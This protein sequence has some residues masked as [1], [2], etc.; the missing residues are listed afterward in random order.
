M[1]RRLNAAVVQALRQP[2][3]AQRLTELGFEIIG[4]T[5]EE[6]AAWTAAQLPKWDALVR[7][8]AIRPE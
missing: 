7:T 6:F 1:I 2:D 4:G 5:P 8:A 3:L